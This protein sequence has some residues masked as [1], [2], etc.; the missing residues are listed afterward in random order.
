MSAAPDPGLFYT[1]L[2]LRKLHELRPFRRV[3]DASAEGRY[4]AVLA[5]QLPGAA[6][7]GAEEAWAPV[8]SELRLRRRDEG[9]DLTDIRIAAAPLAGVDIALFEGVFERLDAA[10]ALDLTDAWLGNAS[11]VL[12]ALPAAFPMVPPGLAARFVA[13]E[14]AVCLLSAD[15]ERVRQAAQLHTVIPAIVQRITGAA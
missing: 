9:L 14:R 2:M 5:E 7:I 12:V 3:L 1:A 15:G 13:G 11:L 8:L 10:G 6:W 4:R